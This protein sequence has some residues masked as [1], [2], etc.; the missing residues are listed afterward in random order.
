MVVPSGAAGAVG[1]ATTEREREK[2]ESLQLL[3]IMMRP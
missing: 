2:D 3:V 1:E